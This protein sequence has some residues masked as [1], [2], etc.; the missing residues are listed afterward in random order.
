[1]IE[2]QEQK[3]QH[4]NKSMYKRFSKNSQMGA[5]TKKREHDEGGCIE[6]IIIYYT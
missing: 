3:Q 1:M 6:T 2:R 5:T 4:K